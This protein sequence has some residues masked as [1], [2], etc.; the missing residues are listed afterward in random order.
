MKPNRVLKNSKVDKPLNRLTKK[1]KKKDLNYL[2]R[3]QTRNITTDLKDSKRIFS[4]KCM[5]T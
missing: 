2:L 5:P 3:N 4:K 1:K